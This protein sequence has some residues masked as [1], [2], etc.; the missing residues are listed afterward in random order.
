M[1]E[2]TGHCLC[3]AIHYRVNAEPVAYFACHC[4]DCQRRS[5]SAFAL[6]MIVQREYLE[7][8]SGQTAPYKAMLSGARSK[9]GQMCA[10]C[11]TYLWGDSKNPGFAVIQPG[12]LIQPCGLVP[13][14]HLWLREAQPWFVLPPGAKAYDT[15]PD[16]PGELARLWVV[17]QSGED[18]STIA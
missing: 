16:D 1:T 8:F 9:T 2:R 14:A 17:A 6:S 13:V 18:H 7:L 3:S 4:T 11:G 12:T 10:E 5:G 15:Q